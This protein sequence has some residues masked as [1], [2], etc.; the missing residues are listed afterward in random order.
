MNHVFPFFIATSPTKGSEQYV[1]LATDPA[2]AKVSGAY[3]A[4]GKETK[5]GGSPLSLDQGVQKRINDLAET[6]AS[7]FL[8][9]RQGER[10]A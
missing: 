8:R 6:W 2:L 1:R 4:S 3:F 5:D 9:S 10:R 7:P